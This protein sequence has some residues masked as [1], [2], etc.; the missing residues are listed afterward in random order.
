[1]NKLKPYPKYKESGVECLPA[2]KAGLGK[3]PEG[4][5]ILPIKALGTFE[6]SGIDKKSKRGEPEVKMV[7]YTDVYGNKARELWNDNK[8]MQVTTS[9]E[10]AKKYLLNKGDILFT[11]SSETIDE[12][13]ESSVVMENLE[14]TVFSY[15]LIRLTV[16]KNINLNFK[17]YL[18][19]NNFV[20][21]QFS[22][23]ARGTTRKTLNRKD[24][25]NALV[26]LPPLDIQQQIGSY[27]DRKTTQIEKY[28]K[29]LKKQIKLLKEYRQKVIS[30]A[31]TCGFDENG[32]L[33][34]KPQSLPAEGWKDSGIEW[35]GNIPKKWRL[36]KNRSIFQ[37]LNNKV[38]KSSD[39]FTLLSLTLN[40]VIARDMEN[41]Q[42]KFP[43]TFDSYKIVKPKN[44]IFCLFDIE[45]TPRTVGI[46]TLHGMITGAYT[47]FKCTKLVNPK[48]IYYYYLSLDFNKRLGSLY[49]GLRKTISTSR[50]LNIASPVPPLQQQQKIVKYL[51]RKSS[52]I[53]K[54]IEK[55]QEQID[56]MQEY[57]QSLISKVVTG[58]VTVK[59]F[60][61]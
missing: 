15:H 55:V 5:K 52:R 39:N 35:L 31:V 34:Q 12:I 36:Q 29:K 19:K 56:L 4:W 44:L 28:I 16:K 21:S 26:L 38:G 20:L 6:A 18:F 51:D 48:Y 50:F 2:G 1:M 42:G 59:G 53:D 11:P 7:N 10:K 43:A 57:K 27:L 60:V 54:Q 22:S 8:Y 25:K 49:S 33:R 24:F 9:K 61:T 3:I 14:N 13:G 41:P 30:Q 45:E 46:T 40:G 23:R 58:K 37:E 32:N 17:K 47:V